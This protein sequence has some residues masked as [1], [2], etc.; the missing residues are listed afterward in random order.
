MMK[1]QRGIFRYYAECRNVRS[2]VN[3]RRWENEGIEE[4]DSVGGGGD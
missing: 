4:N 2:E 1:K 3:E